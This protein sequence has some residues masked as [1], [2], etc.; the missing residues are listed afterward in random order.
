MLTSHAV[1]VPFA[2]YNDGTGPASYLAH[3]AGR[4]HHGLI[5]GESGAGKSRALEAITHG[6]LDRVPTMLVHLDGQDG[7]ASPAVWEMATLRGGPDRADEILDVLEKQLDGRQYMRA[8]LGLD[9][10]EPTDDIPLVLVV[11]E[12]MHALLDQTRANRFA[13]L[14]RKGAKCGLGLL[15]ATEHLHLYD[16]FAESTP[17]RTTLLTGNRIALHTNDAVSLAV[18]ARHGFASL[19]ING[20]ASDGFTALPGLDAHPAPFSLTPA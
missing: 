14:G 6:L 18:L 3:T 9:G 4:T 1:L 15:A 19:G 12:E 10:L 17:L 7:N 20:T 5:I 13:A 11:L 8:D 2:S 16:T